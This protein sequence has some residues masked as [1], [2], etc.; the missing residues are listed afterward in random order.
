MREGSPREKR[1]RILRDELVHSGVLVPDA[2]PRLY[3][4]ATDYEFT[5]A[6]SAAGI[7]KDGNASGPSLWKDTKS[8]QSLKDHLAVT[9][10]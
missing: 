5:S 7:V 8:G 4:F 3:R 10:P 6:S 1:D 2:D 9:R